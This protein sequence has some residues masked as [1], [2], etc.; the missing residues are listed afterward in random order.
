M[1]ELFQAH[2]FYFLLAGISTTLFV[3]K[4]G[5]QLVGPDDLPWLEDG[6][7]SDLHHDPTA[8][9]NLFSLQALLA[10]FMGVGWLGL[11]ASS[12]WGW[13]LIATLAVAGS[14]GLALMFATALLASRVQRLQS[15]RSVNR[16]SLIGTP[17]KVYLTVP[18]KGLGEGQVEVTLAGS[19]KILKAVN[20]GDQVAPSF[21]DVTVVG[22]EGQSLVV[23][24][25]NSK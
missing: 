15:V 17:A 21:S 23:T 4:L 18:P 19:K 25:K 10:L 13:G 11:A 2:P 3:L 5:A 16:W 7:L 6:D 9:F 14:F 8:E 22:I 20:Q 1:T 24:K 12:E